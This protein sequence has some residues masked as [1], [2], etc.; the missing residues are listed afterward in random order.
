MSNHN[1]RMLPKVRD[2][3]SYLYA[4]RCRVDQDDKAI[5]LH[6]QQGKTAVPCS[7]LTLLMLGPGTTITHAAI[8]TLADN[9]CTVLWTGESG[10]R[11]YA[12][13]LGETRS[14]QRLLHQARLCSNPAFRLK[15]VRRMYEIR[16]P[17][18]LDPA[19]TLQQIRGKEGI[20]VRES[21]A[22]ASRETSVPWSGRSYQRDDWRS[23]D[24]VNRALSAANSCLYGISH[25]AIL[26]AGYSPGLGF[27]HTGKLLSFVY[28][29]ADLYK[30]DIT[31]PAAFQ[32]AKDGEDGVEGR[33]RRFCRDYFRE[34][35]LLNRII[36]DI[37]RVLDVGPL[38]TEDAFDADAAAPGDLWDPESG[39]VPGGVNQADLMGDS[40]P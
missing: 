40:M 21:Y 27:V 9:G 1:L 12:Q 23:A 38:P 20:R 15:V 18:P 10:V 39:G 17:E 5:S 28:D 32:A 37:D 24:P 29:I 30:V 22:K 8:R 7:A 31:I 3:W 25:A 11:L 16:F 35:R 6:D 26:S 14:A 34:Q 19:L 4:E 13:G 33:V 2:S 36:D